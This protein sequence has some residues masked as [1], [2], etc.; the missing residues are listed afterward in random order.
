MARRRDDPQPRWRTQLR[1]AR[2][3]FREIFPGGF[4]DPTYLDWERD[5]EAR[6]ASPSERPKAP[7]KWAAHQ[8]FLWV[9][10]REEYETWP[11]D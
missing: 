7:Y 9:T 10:Q 6:K 8:S 5:G 2:S 3:R 1:A 11:W 4:T